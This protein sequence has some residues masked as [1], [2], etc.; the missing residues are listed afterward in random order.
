MTWNKWVQ[1]WERQLTLTRPA[2]LHSRT[3]RRLVLSKQM[4]SLL[5]FQK[6]TETQVQSANN[7]QLP[8]HCFGSEPLPLSSF[9]S[10]KPPAAEHL[11]VRGCRPGGFPPEQA[12]VTVRSLFSSERLLRLTCLHLH[13]SQLNWMGGWIGVIVIS[14][15]AKRPGV[16]L[17]VENTLCMT[18][19]FAGGQLDPGMQAC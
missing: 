4:Y 8:W 11:T 16:L 6:G 13:V 18:R 7:A 19:R 15:H 3:S 9:S 1:K 5:F 2:V 10:S 14:N 12:P 17:S